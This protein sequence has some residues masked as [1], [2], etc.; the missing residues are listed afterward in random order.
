[1]SI[2]VTVNENTQAVTVNDSPIAVIVDDSP[3]LVTF[4]C[5]LPVNIDAIIEAWMNARPAYQSNEAAADPLIGNLAVGKT[6]WAAHGNVEVSEG[7][8][9][10]VV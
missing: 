1:M 5:Y 2:Y 3:I 7:T 9:M 10:R 8:F 6:Y 4:P